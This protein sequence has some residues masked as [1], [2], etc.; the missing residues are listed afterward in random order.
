MDDNSMSNSIPL[1]YSAFLQFIYAY[2]APGTFYAQDKSTADFTTVT[3]DDWVRFG[4]ERHDM[5]QRES[6]AE[7]VKSGVLK[8]YSKEV[9]QCIKS[10]ISKGHPDFY[11]LR[12]F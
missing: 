1:F 7:T 9:L 4:N 11:F 5:A 6:E 10:Q 8:K 3:N 2:S 12:T